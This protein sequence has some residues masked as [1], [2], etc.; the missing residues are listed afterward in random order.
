[1]YVA[2]HTDQSATEQ[3]L[4]TGSALTCIME[5]PGSN[6]CRITAVALVLVV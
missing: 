6:L 4:L 1:M 2:Q 3:V 5:V